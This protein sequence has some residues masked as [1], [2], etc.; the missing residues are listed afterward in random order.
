MRILTT[1]N[2]LK[3]AFAYFV[4]IRPRVMLQKVKSVKSYKVAQA[5][6]RAF[7]L[8]RA[9]RENRIQ[10]FVNLNRINNRNLLS[11]PP[12]DLRAVFC[13]TIVGPEVFRQGK[14]KFSMIHRVAVRDFL[15]ALSL[16]ESV[17]V[18]GGELDRLN[19]THSSYIDSVDLNL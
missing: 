18:A 7:Y 16:T 9:L 6:A 3:K 10:K 12:D 15:S 19:T 14:V 17:E 13:P 4:G 5:K 11:D 1:L 2:S 8:T